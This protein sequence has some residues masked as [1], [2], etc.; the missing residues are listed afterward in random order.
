[1]KALA[2]ILS[3]AITLHGY[4]QEYSYKQ[5]TTA[6]GLPS[7]VVYSAYQDSKGF[8]WFCTNAGVSRFNG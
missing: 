4:A 8:I 3:L 1:M 7:N 2:I 6:D 5:F